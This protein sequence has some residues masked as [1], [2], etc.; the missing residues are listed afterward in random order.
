MGSFLQHTIALEYNVFDTEGAAEVQR[1]ICAGYAGLHGS[2]WRLRDLKTD[3]EWTGLDQGW[4]E[5]DYGNVTLSSVKEVSDGNTSAEDA[6]YL[7]A[8]LFRYENGKK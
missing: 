6:E 4:Y 5:G 3:C 2:V 7:G 8:S 1:C